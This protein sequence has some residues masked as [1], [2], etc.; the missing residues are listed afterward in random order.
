[1]KLELSTLQAKPGQDLKITI[2]TKP[3]SYVGL[4]G[5]DQSVLLL[6][7]GNDIEKKSVFE[8]LENFN[9]RN[10]YHGWYGGYFPTY[11]NF[12]SSGAIMLTNAKEEPRKFSYLLYFVVTKFPVKF[13]IFLAIRGS[14]LRFR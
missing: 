13:H 2:N 9:T 4:L 1:M 8:E 14:T 11:E 5:V 10:Y 12:E 6:K 3:N 7:S